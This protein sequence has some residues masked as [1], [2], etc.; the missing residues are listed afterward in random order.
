M[1]LE[2]VIV[3]RFDVRFIEAVVLELLLFFKSEQL[4]NTIK[5]IIGNKQIVFLNKCSSS[6]TYCKQNRY[7]IGLKPENSELF[8][9]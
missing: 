3:E 9:T 7:L 5:T 4:V 1:T 8:F 6:S 2:D